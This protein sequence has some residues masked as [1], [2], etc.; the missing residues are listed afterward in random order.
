[1]HRISQW[2]VIEMS[3]GLL[4]LQKKNT[5]KGGDTQ[6]K[7]T[8]NV[9]T[10]YLTQIAKPSKVGKPSLNRGLTTCERFIEWCHIGKAFPPSRHVKHRKHNVAT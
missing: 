10:S 8:K 2:M 7:S 9:C 5:T 6:G 1:V 3:V 4:E